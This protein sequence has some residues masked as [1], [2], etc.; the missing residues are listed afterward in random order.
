MKARLTDDLV[1]VLRPEFAGVEV[2]VVGRQYA[3]GR[4]ISFDVVLPGKRFCTK[5]PA[6]LVEPADLATRAPRAL[7]R[8]ALMPLSRAVR[9]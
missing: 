4:L 3:G 9:S 1:G 5:V 6:K 8:C 7:R 2:D